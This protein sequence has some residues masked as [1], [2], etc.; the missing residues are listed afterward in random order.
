MPS[1]VC[2]VYQWATY[3]GVERVFL[4]RALAFESIAVDVDIDVYYGADGGGLGAFLKAIET[5]KIG[6]RIRVVERFE[7]ELYEAVFVIDSPGMLPKEL[8]ETT[9]WLVECHTP[10]AA[11]R[12]YLDELPP[13]VVEIIVPSVTFAT[14][15]SRERPH[16]AG[17]MRVL[18]NCVAPSG[19]DNSPRLPA[20]RRTPLLY[21]GRLDDLKN[22]A[23]FLDLV[24]ELERREPGGFFGVVLGPEVPGYD[25]DARVER[26]GLRG[27][28]VRMPPLQFLR[29]QTFLRAW[30]KISGV[31]ISPSNGESFGLA[32]AES[33]TAGV[34]VLLSNLPEHAE[35]VDGDMRY[36]YDPRDVVAGADKVQRLIADYGDH[37][38]RMLER[39]KAFGSEAFVSDW[40]ALM[41]ALGMVE[42][43]AV[44]G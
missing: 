12:T 24:C 1:K 23:G 35:L 32:A 20:W 39:A 11:N 21:F 5:L 18:H 42:T 3:G 29:T 9:K 34:P 28:V 38:Q 14:L 19:N 10:Y 13:G 41:A 17:R 40:R 15:L 25:F 4:N 27:T 6:H 22:P 44:I 8:P 2:F 31:M 36:L 33:I 7:P 30:Q 43:E 26:A 37:S 16:L